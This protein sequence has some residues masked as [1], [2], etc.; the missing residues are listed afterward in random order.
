LVAAAEGALKG[1]EGAAFGTLIERPKL[2]PPPS[3]AA[4]ASNVMETRE[5]PIR[6]AAKNFFM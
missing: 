5:R 2:A 3:R 1:E 4:E 6:R